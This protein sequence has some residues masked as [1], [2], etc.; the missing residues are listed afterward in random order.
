M[1]VASDNQLHVGGHNKLLL[2]MV[3][4]FINFGLPHDDNG[5]LM[6]GVEHVSHFQA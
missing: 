3:A 5:Y 2:T 4:S 1:K 6:L